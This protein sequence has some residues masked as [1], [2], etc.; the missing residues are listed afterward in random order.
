MADKIKKA[1]QMHGLGKQR[2]ANPET[3]LVFNSIDIKHMDNTEGMA[4]FEKIWESSL[5]AD[6]RVASA[7]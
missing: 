7:H 3:C 1:S 2:K 5:S 4:P 6:N